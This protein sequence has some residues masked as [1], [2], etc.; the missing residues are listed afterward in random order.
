MRAH[1]WHRGV[2][3]SQQCAVVRGARARL[4]GKRMQGLMQEYPLTIQHIFTRAVRLFPRQEIVTRT[5][6]G[7]HR[8]TYAEFGERVAPLANALAG[9]GW[10]PRDL[11]ATL[12]WNNLLHLKLY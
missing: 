6:N 9:I 5:D 8:Y 11:V 4:E 7:F 3:A 12:G 10:R 1:L 2:V